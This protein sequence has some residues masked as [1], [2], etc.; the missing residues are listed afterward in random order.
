V[1]ATRKLAQ[2]L[3]RDE[4]NPAQR[5]PIVRL[6]AAREDVQ[7]LLAVVAEQSQ[8]DD[9]LIRAAYAAGLQ[10]IFPQA[11]PL[12]MT[13]DNWW[14]R[15]DIALTRLDR[16]PPTDKGKLIN[17][18]AATILQDQQITIGESELMRV[19]CATLHCPLPQSIR[20]QQG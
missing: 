10:Q 3:L 18:L 6:D 5:V 13:P 14:S 12:Y 19:V 8:V 15:M 4:L 1:Y 2:V 20:D 17:A 16:L 11:K 7:L 9:A